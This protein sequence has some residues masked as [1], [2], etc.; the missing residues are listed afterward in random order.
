MLAEIFPRVASEGAVSRAWTG[1]RSDET[2]PEAQPS[3][4]SKQ[5]QL[6]RGVGWVGGRHDAA[7]K[8]AHR[9]LK[10][11]SPLW[12]DAGSGRQAG[13]ST[14]PEALAAGRTLGDVMWRKGVH[15]GHVGAGRV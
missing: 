7:G 2:W 5:L 10:S 15:L 1:A 14:P 8:Q 3:L 12:H 13:Q 9:G 4:F 6:P 11:P